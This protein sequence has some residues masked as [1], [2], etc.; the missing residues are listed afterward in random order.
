MDFKPPQNHLLRNF[1]DKTTK[2]H[3]L[4]YVDI[5]N[6]YLRIVKYTE[7]VEVVECSQLVYFLFANPVLRK[8]ILNSLES[9]TKP[10]NL[11][12]IVMI[13]PIIYLKIILFI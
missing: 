2:W 10:C 12:Y 5:T 3:N 7:K 1:K 6:Y 8:S 11:D 9:R 4:T 13:Y